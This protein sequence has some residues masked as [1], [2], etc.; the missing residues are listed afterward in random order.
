[1]DRVEDPLTPQRL[2]VMQIVASALVL[3]VL[4][5]LAVALYVVLIHNEGRGTGVPPEVPMMSLL[6]GGFLAVM[7]VLSF[8]VPNV[9]TGS[10]LRGIAAGT[11]GP[12]PGMPVPADDAGK[13]LVVYQTTRLIGWSMLEGAC[14]FALVAYLV[15]GQLYALAFVAVGL[16]LLLLRFPTESRA[17]GWLQSQT[18]QL[19]LLRLQRGSGGSA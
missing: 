7:I 12:R 10:N 5:F 11:W 8:I 18:E 13:L 1:M 14:F 6:S 19:A 2:R 4:T 17:R 15:E 16:A 3:G 9:V